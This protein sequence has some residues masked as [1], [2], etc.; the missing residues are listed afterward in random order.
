MQTAI[1]KTE[2]YKEVSLL[3]DDKLSEVKDF[4]EFILSRQEPAK[5]KVIQLK[6][7]WAGRGFEKVSDLE[8]ELKSIRKKTMQSILK[9]D[10]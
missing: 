9:K 4:I 1:L 10:I 2:I 7:I 8:K 3:R 5:K 6:G